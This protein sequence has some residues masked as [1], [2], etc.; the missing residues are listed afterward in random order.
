VK[1]SKRSFVIGN[2]TEKKVM[3]LPRFFWWLLLALIGLL[4]LAAGAAALYVVRASPDHEGNLRMAGLKAEVSIE[5][6]Q[7]GI[8]T[9]RAAS[10]ED[11]AFGLG[12]AHAQDRLWQLQTHLRI[13]SG[14][15]AEA[16]GPAALDNDK[17]LRALGVKRAA[18]AQW[19]KLGLD[20]RNVLQAYADGVNS[21]IEHHT[22]ARPPELMVLGV[23]AE[24]W[25][26]QDSLA[27]S[28]M[29][30]WD[31]GGNWNSE[32]LRLRM[33]LTLPVERVNE[34]IPPY[35]GEK[36][37]ATADYAAMFRDMKLGGAL[38]APG[39]TR[40]AHL[41]WMDVLLAAAPPS[42]IE[43][44]G[45][46]NWVVAGTHTATGKPLLANDPH[47]KITAPALWYFARIEVGGAQPYKVAG[48]TMPG[49]PGVVLGQNEH[50][51]WG[52]TNTGPDV[53]DLYLEKLNPADRT[54]VQTPT[55]WAP[56]QSVEEVIKVKG[57]A[58][59]LLTVRSS[60]HGPVISDAG[61]ASG[62][63][64][65][66]SGYALAM[67]WTALD[68][69]VDPISVS[70]T[71]QRA[72]SAEEFVQAASSGWVSPMQNMVVAD[73]RGD[74][75]N[76]AVV[77]AGR[78]PL[79]GPDHDLKGL[80][81]APGW[82]AK[83]DWQG[84]LAHEQTPREANPSRGWIATAN[85]RI[86]AADYPHFISSDWA[87]P[88][89]QQR[90]EQMLTAKP[91]HSIDDL[92]VMQ[93]DVQSLATQSVLPWLLAAKSEHPLYAAAQKALQGFD[94]QMS[95]D[96]AAP[97]I[98]NAWAR[99]M[100]RAV[101]IDELGGAAVY[102]KV[103][104][105]RSFRDA[106]DAMIAGNNTWWCDDKGT[107]ATETCEAQAGVALTRALD[108][109]QQRFGKDVSKWR[110]GKAHQARSEHRPFSR[111]KALAPMFELRVP[112]GG[113]SYTV[114][115][116]RVALQPDG[117]TGEL[118]LNEH[119]ASL[120]ALYDLNDPRQS[121]VMHSSGQSGL[122]WSQHYASFVKPWADVQYVPLWVQ[123]EKAR[124]GGVLRLLPAQ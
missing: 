24:K 38:A 40:T 112:T 122:P 65:G 88:Y 93:A 95:A 55:G 117:T 82:D 43:G 64:A 86:H 83:Y 85:Q 23:P 26:P 35:P 12:V 124:A 52:F 42:G 58:D 104:P 11:A 1:R 28:I 31:L 119:A 99:Q 34:L 102:D 37:L 59:V 106:M 84:W 113:D 39:S 44:V 67:R 69:D 5:R 62:T 81:P 111:V 3:N 47:L 71:M 54:Q 48:A 21:I 25:T 94:G 41:P 19:A 27:W 51:A 107:P 13:G 105:G 10:I 101:F 73:K 97:L 30:S 92:A 78:V 29:M 108:E 33:A 103:V 61:G 57:G 17:F 118:Y 96:A 100:T 20:S 115:V 109:L 72:T 121:R 46:N 53:Q 15:M 6:D 9:I 77:S 116:S 4:V 50:I 2:C 16:F 98:F 14:R 76:I 56:L 110:W 123:G 36:P 22:K 75:G 80:V 70:L 114:N 8:P 32:L 68:P 79:R 49:L 91:K 66:E 90:I 18:Q 7:Q 63:V 60:R 89:R 120:R 74:H 87:L 45:S